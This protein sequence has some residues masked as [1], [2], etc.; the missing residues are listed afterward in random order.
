MTQLS[1][2]SGVER[3]LFLNFKPLSTCPTTRERNFLAAW[4]HRGPS[5][6][7]PSGLCT[8]VSKLPTFAPDAGFRCVP[9]PRSSITARHLI[10]AATL[11]AALEGFLR[12]PGRTRESGTGQEIEALLSLSFLSSVLSL[13]LPLGLYTPSLSAFHSADGQLTSLDYI[14]L[15]PSSLPTCSAAAAALNPDGNFQP[16]IGAKNPQRFSVISIILPSIQCVCK[17]RYFRTRA[18]NSLALG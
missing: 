12:A 1:P 4:G 2:T 13:T 18:R 5:P 7:F 9:L 6:P 16:V 8:P 17:R 15:P 14:D 3:V 11:E 10:F